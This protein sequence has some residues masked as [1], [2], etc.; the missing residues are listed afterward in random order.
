M[1]SLVLATAAFTCSMMSAQDYQDHLIYSRMEGDHASIRIN[2]GLGMD[3]MLL[4]TA[5]I[6]QLVMNG[7]YLLYIK[8][9]LANGWFGNLLNSGQWVRRTVNGGSEFVLFNN[10]DFLV[11][12]DLFESDSTS[13]VSYGCNIYN[14]SFD[15]ATVLGTMS[16]ICDDDAP[17]IR[18]SDG[19]V[20][21]HNVFASLFTVARDGTGRTPIPNTTAF[22]TWPVWSPD[23]EWILFSRS[24]GLYAAGVEYGLNVVNY[25]K[26]K[27]NGDSLTQLTWNAPTDSATFTSNAVWSEDGRSIF[28]AG[29][30]N[31]QYGLLEIA[32]DGSTF[33]DHIPTAA[34]GLIHYI[35][36]TMPTRL[37]IGIEKFEAQQVTVFPN[38][39]RD[40][41]IVQWNSTRPGVADV[42]L[43]DALGRLTWQRSRALL[44]RVEVDLGEY[45]PGSY[46]LRIVPLDSPARVVRVSKI[47]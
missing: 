42:Q 45:P 5:T 27:L 43:L 21:G 15:N 6:P 13:A 11:G 29:T 24:N 1:R 14:N 44:N 37:A 38:P 16:G 36:G 22:D 23:G 26:I 7:R 41:V 9:S 10:N 28:A 34:G 3:A 39:T 46:F 8:G 20:V 30:L 33:A 25:Y 4:D 12:Y 31:G 32:A 35:T 17:R 19:L 47:Q 40:R 2:D 18:Q